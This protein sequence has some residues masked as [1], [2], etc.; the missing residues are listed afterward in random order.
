MTMHE[1]VEWA[2]GRFPPLPRYLTL[3]QVLSE[4]EDGS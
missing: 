1:I 3:D 4:M 2:S